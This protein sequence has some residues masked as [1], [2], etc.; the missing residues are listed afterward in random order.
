M[1]AGDVGQESVGERELHR[2]FLNQYYGISRWFYDGTRKYYLLGRDETLGALL[3]EPWSSLIE[4][5]PGTGRNLRRL[6]AARAEAEYGGI[7]ASDAMLEFARRRID[8]APLAQGFAETADYASVLG[9]PPQRILFSYCLSMV[10]QP[11]VALEN[12]R[13]QLAPGGKIVIVDFA[14]CAKMPGVFRVALREWLETFHVKPLSEEF[15]RL[16][17][18]KLKFGRGRYWVRATISKG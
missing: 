7:E 5:G 2:R 14:D 8:W 6:R 3:R 11:A 16:F 13:K 18:V 10:Q 4:V 12:A 15:L 17:D 1:N 9:V